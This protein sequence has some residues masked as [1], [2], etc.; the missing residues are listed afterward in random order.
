MLFRSGAR[1]AKVNEDPAEGVDIEVKKDGA[2]IAKLIS[3][4]KGKYTFQIPVSTDDIN[5]DYVIYISKDGFVPKMININAY[6]SKN[7]FGNYPF[8]K[9]DF[10]MDLSLLKTT[11]KDI[12]LDKPSAKIA[13]DPMK[14]HK[15]DFDHVYYTKV[16]QKEEQKMI[17]N[18]DAYFKN[19]AKK[20]KKEEELLAKNK[21]A[22]DAKL[23]AEEEAK[24]KANE[25]IQKLA[26]MKAK[27]EADRIL[28]QNLE[29]MKQEMK[30]KHIADSLA[31]VQRKKEMESGNAKLEIK[32][33]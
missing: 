5:N 23:K 18:S 31:E 8:A 7:E 13:W 15:F 33:L 9:Y 21:V 30:K 1:T 22:A 12:V 11:I 16:I 26:A 27:E 28:Q 3:G 19:F 14:L 17:P 2:T 10:E 20:K 29:A 25:E 32:K 24:K 4:K 6:L